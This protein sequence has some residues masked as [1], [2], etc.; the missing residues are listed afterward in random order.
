MKRPNKVMRNAAAAM[1]AY[2]VG[3]IVLTVFANTV[4]AEDAFEIRKVEQP[5]LCV[6]GQQAMPCAWMLAMMQRMRARCGL[7]M[8]CA[9]QK[10][11]ALKD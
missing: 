8:G 4:Q 6:V 5:R 9:G 10:T 1:L 3:F 11:C 7:N 2:V